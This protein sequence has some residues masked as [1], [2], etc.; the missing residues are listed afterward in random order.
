MCPVRLICNNYKTN[1]SEGRQQYNHCNANIYALETHTHIF[2][3]IAYCV[4]Y[5]ALNSNVAE[6]V[7][8]TLHGPVLLGVHTPTFT[9]LRMAISVA[10]NHIWLDTNHLISWQVFA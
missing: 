1:N 6:A 4:A 5:D 9:A 10:S 7:A 8:Y 2:D 3:R